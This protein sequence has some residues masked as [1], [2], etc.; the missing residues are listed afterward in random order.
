MKKLAAT[1]FCAS[2]I[3]LIHKLYIHF[4]HSSSTFVKLFIQKVTTKLLL[5]HPN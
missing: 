5:F 2:I 4:I 1:L 3:Y